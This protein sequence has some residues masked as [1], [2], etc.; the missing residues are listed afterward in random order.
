MSIR[1]QSSGLLSDW[2]DIKAE[3]LDVDI[4]KE[5]DS[6]TIERIK[7]KLE[8]KKQLDELTKRDDFTTVKALDDSI[9]AI[10]GDI[11]SS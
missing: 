6:L 11:T 7:N 9:Q 8:F 5:R 1:R 10:L 3:V 4:E 2:L